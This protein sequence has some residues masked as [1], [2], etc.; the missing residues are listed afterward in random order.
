MKLP[1]KYEGATPGP[2]QRK[3]KEADKDY[4]RIRGTHLGCRFKIA[5][6]HQAEYKT[7]DTDAYRI[8]NERE[9][10]ESAANA[11]LISDA[12]LLAAV[13]VE[14][15][16]ALGRYIE[17]GDQFKILD[18]GDIEAVKNWAAKMAETKASLRTTLES[19]KEFSV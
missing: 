5:N 14:L 7:P 19:T 15:R 9:A 13:V 16:T 2:W 1:K 10:A 3:S 4:I 8:I 18:A 17:L 6:V 12:P 11:I